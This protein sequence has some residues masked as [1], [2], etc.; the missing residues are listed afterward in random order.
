SRYKEKETMNALIAAL[1]L[2]AFQADDE[3]NSRRPEARPRLLERGGGTKETEAAVE[4]AL[5]WL[6]KNQPA[7][8][9]WKAPTEEFRVGVTALSVLAFLG[10]GHG[11]ASER[12]GDT[13]KRGLQ[14]LVASQDADG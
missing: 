7:D 6:A 8:H 3:F 13:V 5:A 10:A 1:V 11:P 14:V 4:K 2:C 12:H 9:S